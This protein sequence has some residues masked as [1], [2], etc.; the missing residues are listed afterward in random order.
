MIAKEREKQTEA[1]ELVNQLQE[2]LKKIE[3]L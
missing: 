2:Q 3:A 1:Q